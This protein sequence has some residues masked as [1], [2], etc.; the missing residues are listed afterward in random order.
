MSINVISIAGRAGSGKD[1]AADYLVS[2]R[3]YIKYNLALPIKKALNAMFGWSMDLWENREWKETVIP[4]YGK[5][6]R[7]MAQT[8]GTE[9]GREWITP[10]IWLLMAEEFI[11]S[12]SANYENCEGV[13]IPDLR[14]DNEAEFLKHKL[15]H[16]DHVNK[17]AVFEIWRYDV[18]KIDNYYHS[19]ENGVSDFYTDEFIRNNGTLNNLEKAIIY[20]ERDI[21]NEI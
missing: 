15:R 19:S 14:F 4:R 21:N 16:N 6:P 11:E 9:W 5:S 2:N 8:L 20:A 1:T 18:I 17:T 12:I 10:E 3:N 13:V 7:F